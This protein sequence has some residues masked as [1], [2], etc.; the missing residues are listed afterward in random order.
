MYQVEKG[1]QLTLFPQGTREHASLLVL[2]GS[3]KARQTTVTSGRKLSAY[4][5]RSDPVGLLAKMLLDMSHWD[6]MRCFLTWQTSD[7]PHKRLLFQLVPSEPLTEGTEFL[8]LP[9]PTAADAWNKRDS[10]KR[11]NRIGTVH[12][13]EKKTNN[14]TCQN[15]YTALA[16]MM[17]TPT[18]SMWKGAAKKRYKGS[19][20]YRASFTQEALRNGPEDAQ[21]INPNYLE[22]I[23]GFPIKWTE[24][25]PSETQLYPSKSI[26]S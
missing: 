10:R 13:N 21:Y 18:A 5:K 19:E 23:M 8:S 25:S 3:E 17:P 22:L 6:S 14:P 24:L 11:F 12:F 16:F 9:T 4:W 26:P 20:E 1:E 2:P 15:L 7:T